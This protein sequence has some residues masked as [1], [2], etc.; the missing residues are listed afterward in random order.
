MTLSIWPLAWNTVLRVCFKV[1]K[2][3]PKVDTYTNWPLYLVEPQVPSWT[4]LNSLWQIFNNVLEMF[5]R[6]FELR[7]G[8]CGDHLCTVNS[9][10]WSRTQF[11]MIWALWHNSLDRNHHQHLGSLWCLNAA[12]LVPRGLKCTRNVSPTPFHHQHQLEPLIQGGM[13]HAFMLITPNS[14]PTIWMSPQKST[15]FYITSV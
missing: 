10:S 13:V 15:K 2:T 8:D 12:H 1:N 4:C 7:S 3:K 6:P 14:D 11:E 9:F 5:L